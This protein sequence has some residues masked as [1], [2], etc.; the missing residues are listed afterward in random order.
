M[1]DREEKK[2]TH[3]TTS[4]GI[5]LEKVEQTLDKIAHQL[6]STKKLID[7]TILPNINLEKVQQ[8]LDKV[9]EM[10]DNKKLPYTNVWLCID[11]EKVRQRIHNINAQIDEIHRKFEH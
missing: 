10:I 2:S 9:A 5:D 3:R 11:F 4:P 8:T 6:D 1:L 7:L